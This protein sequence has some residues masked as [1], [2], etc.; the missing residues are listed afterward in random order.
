MATT[1]DN[2]V[3]EDLDSIPDDSNDETVV[4]DYT[5]PEPS[6]THLY[7]ETVV[8]D[9]TLPVP[10]YIH[11]YNAVP[12]QISQADTSVTYSKDPDLILPK[13]CARRN[14]GDDA[15]VKDARGRRQCTPRSCRTP[16]W[17]VVLIVIGLLILIAVIVG[18]V[19]FQGQSI[20]GQR[21]SGLYLLISARW[22]CVT[23][24]LSL[25]LPPSSSPLSFTLPP[26][27]SSP[28]SFLSSSPTPLS[29]PLPS[30]SSPPL[31]LSINTGLNTLYICMF[32]P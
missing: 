15:Q 9:Y 16:C 4:E 29:L 19:L 7:Y 21:L 24:F 23:F 10:A 18:I 12:E 28:L 20:R 2:H 14:E 32:S 3:Y 5:L 27:L 22:P 1:Q 17:A 13:R 31:S 30:L 11:V 6:Y 26:S 8:E 25:P